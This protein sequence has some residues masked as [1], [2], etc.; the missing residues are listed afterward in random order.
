[1]SGLLVPAE[2]PQKLADALE[3]LLD[4]GELRARLKTNA[5]DTSGRFDVDSM[6][7]SIAKRL[8]AI[9]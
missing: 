6:L 8:R 7:E 1:M 4:E 5:K 2:D 9:V 3:R